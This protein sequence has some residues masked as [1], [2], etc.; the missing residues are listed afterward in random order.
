MPSTPPRCRER[1]SWRRSCAIKAKAGLPQDGR[2]R[3]GRPGG[4]YQ[5]QYD[6]RTLTPWGGAIAA[7]S[8]QGWEAFCCLDNDAAGYAARNAFKV[9][10]LI[11]KK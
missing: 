7:W 1:R 2:L 8:R 3:A 4:P 11:G 10:A 5:G 6:C 9:Q